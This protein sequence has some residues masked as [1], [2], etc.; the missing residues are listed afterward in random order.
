MEKRNKGDALNR[1][2]TILL[3]SLPFLL[4]GCGSANMPAGNPKVDKVN[5]L[6]DLVA[7]KFPDRN[8]YLGAATHYKLFGTKTID[9]L[10]REFSYITPANDFKQTSVH[11]KPGQW[12]WTAADAWVEHCRRNGQVMRLHAP[13]SP[14]CSK[15]VK[16]DER[17]GEELA[18]ML[19]EYLTA[20]CMKYNTVPRIRWLDVVNETIDKKDGDWFGPRPGTDKWE[21]PWP[22]MGFDDNHE[23]KP[24]I[25]IKKAFEIANRY[26]TN[27]KLIINQHGALEPFV[28]EKMKALVGY[29]RDNNLKVDGLGWQAHIDLGWEK[30]PDNM[31]RLAEIVQWCHANGLE[32]HITEFN[33]WLKE[34]HAGK[35]EEQAKTFASIS[36]VLLDHSRTGK[37][38]INF[39]QIR[40]SETP[41]QQWDG[42]IFDEEWE[43]KPAYDSLY[44]LIERY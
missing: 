37:V 29:L 42:C 18:V 38:G 7:E 40:A 9:L 33:V 14:Q 35:W 15:W 36:K 21:N 3:L 19:D 27:M 41:N 2:L 31:E 23:L 13:I 25:Y 4:F 12:S 20:L 10:D 5:G 32:F 22:K 6:R 11:P 26:A 16:S 8:F 28:W 30:V 1:Y 17:T 39:W 34:D 44:S 43:A 24:P